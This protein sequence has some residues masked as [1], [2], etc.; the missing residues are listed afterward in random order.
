MKWL[1]N[2]LG[3]LFLILVCPPFAILMWYTNSHLQGSLQQLGLFLKQE[4]IFRGIYEI[5]QPLFFGSPTAWTIIAVFI[6]FEFLLAKYLRG[7]PFKGPITPKGNVP[8]YKANGVAAFLLTVFSFCFCSFYLNLFPATII[9]DEFGAIIGALNCLSLLLCLAFYFKGKFWPSSTDSGTT[10]NF[11]FDYYWGTELYPTFA[12]I[13]LKMFINCRLGMMSW[14]LILLSYAAKQ[15]MLFGLSNAMLVAVALQFIYIGKFFLW[16]TGYLASLDIMHDRAGFYICWGCLVWVP[17][18]YTS[19]SMYLVLH[20]HHLSPFWAVAIFTAGA[21]AILINYLADR[22]RQRIRATAGQCKIWGKT[23]RLTLATYYT[24]TGEQKQNLLLSSGWWGISRH[25]HYLPEIAA[26]FFWSVPALFNHF[27]P[28]FYV[29][30]LT[31]LLLDRAFRD[32]ERCLKKYGGYWKMYC[33]Q[34]PYKII[35]YVL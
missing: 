9:Y 33:E 25:F 16:E 34:V 23:P 20:P 12:G 7:K 1:R 18:I 14:G 21:S 31:V 24:E 17:C 30:F 6:F 4:G 5:W 3:P 29:C 2:T 32:D 13:N 27:A 19:P 8:L 11:I 35:P 26:A 15:E 22:Q 10:G 28:Y